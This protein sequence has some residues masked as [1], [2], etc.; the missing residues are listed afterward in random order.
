MDS[1]WHLS[2]DFPQGIAHITIANYYGDHDY[3]EECDYQEEEEQIELD[4]K[5]INYHPYSIKDQQ[6][7]LRN[8]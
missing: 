4:S 7:L 1:L 5:M 8:V 2:L 6:W 3:Y